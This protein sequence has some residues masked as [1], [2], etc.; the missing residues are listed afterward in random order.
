MLRDTNLS[1]VRAF[2]LPLYASTTSL[3]IVLTSLTNSLV[4]L[5]IIS[6]SLIMSFYRFLI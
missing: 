2:T 5:V 3:A 4:K 1:S 6:I